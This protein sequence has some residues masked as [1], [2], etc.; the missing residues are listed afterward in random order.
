MCEYEHHY[1]FW[2]TMTTCQMEVETCTPAVCL[3]NR[4]QY[5]YE[6][7]SCTV[8]LQIQTCPD[9]SIFFYVFTDPYS[10]NIWVS[11]SQRPP[12]S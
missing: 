11:I 7:H 5:R 6:I 10:C 12:P 2:S 4:Y 3:Y 9:K 1:C 8:A